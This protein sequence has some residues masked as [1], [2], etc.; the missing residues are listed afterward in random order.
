MKTTF[1]ALACAAAMATAAGAST[2]DTLSGEDSAIYSWGLP[3]TAAYGQTFTLA[4]AQ[5]LDNVLFR[6]DDEGTAVSFDLQVF[7]WDGTKATGASLGSAS[8]STAGVDAM[9]DV[10]IDTGGVALGAGAY[11]AFLQATSNGPA[12]WGSIAGFDAY[13]GGEFVFQNNGGDTAQWTTVVWRGDWLGPDYD[14]AF[15]LG[16]A[17]VAPVPLAAALPLLGSGLLALGL[18]GRRKRT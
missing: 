5:S 3:N 17:E 16:F 7:A 15:R 10:S 8:G 12:N 14:L 11:V 18:L 2:I 4:S 13:A 1:T 9:S 6:I